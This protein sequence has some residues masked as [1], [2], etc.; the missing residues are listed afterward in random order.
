V[1]HDDARS[2][3]DAGVDAA[4]TDGALA[5]GDELWAIL[6]EVGG[7]EEEGWDAPL[8]VELRERLGLP[9]DDSVGLGLTYLGITAETLVRAFFA[10]ARPYVRMWSDLLS[11]LEI[12]GASSGD[13]MVGI[14]YHFD[15]KSDP[16]VTIDV[17]HFRKAMSLATPAEF[18]LRNATQEDLWQV[19][20]ALA[21]GDE[22]L[23]EV[24]AW[25]RRIRDRAPLP[26]QLPT[27][28]PATGDARLQ[29]LIVEVW[30]L[31]DLVLAEMRAVGPASEDLAMGIGV[32]GT[33]ASGT[34]EGLLAMLASDRWLIPVVTGAHR[35]VAEAEGVSTVGATVADA[36]D[37]ALAPLRNENDLFTRLTEQLLDLLELPL[38]RHRHELFSNWVCTRV[39]AALADLDPRVHVVDGAIRFRSTG[40]HLATFDAVSPRLHLWTEL[41]TPLV[42]PRGKGR[43]ANIRPDISLVADPLTEPS[44]SPVVVECKQYKKAGNVDFADVVA[45][46]ARGRPS[47]LVVLVDH[48]PVREETVLGHLGDDAALA[49]RIRIIG[50]MT[51][52]DDPADVAFAAAIRS[53]LA[54]R[55]LVASAVGADDQE[56]ADPVEMG[57]DVAVIALRWDAPETDLDLHVT[58]EMPDGDSRTFSHRTMGDPAVTP[59]VY[60]RG[61][62]LAGGGEPEVVG[63]REWVAARY[64]VEVRRFSGRDVAAA[65]A[66]VEITWAGDEVERFEPSGHGGWWEV[67]TK[68]APR[69]EWAGRSR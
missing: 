52:A 13:Q 31:A 56:G 66:T 6:V 1:S 14:A 4:I 36:L 27:P 43:T 41:Q 30:S 54:L 38:W 45:D 15:D 22:D 33:T 58:V 48:G 62:V 16:D 8:A 63:I 29:A 37:Q 19:A 32:P 49:D 28:P 18:D 67:T 46:Y 7:I 21:G 23:V 57:G 11:M 64:R 60:L 20:R 61:D 25:T 68:E 51:L 35:T 26:S 47:A 12:A 42:N 55:P 39:L 5:R 53:R 34:P 65:G 44:R 24:G 69:G 59:F 10:V 40:T 50:A 17:E 2:G 9:L 3:P